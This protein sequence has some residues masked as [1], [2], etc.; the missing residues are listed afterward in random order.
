MDWGWRGKLLFHLVP[1]K[2]SIN[3]IVF[4]QCFG[5]LELAMESQQCVDMTYKTQLTGGWPPPQPDAMW[6][7][8]WLLPY[9][10][11][12]RKT[13]VLTELIDCE[14]VWGGEGVG[15]VFISW[16]DIPPPLETD[17]SL[18]SYSAGLASINIDS[19]VWN[20]HKH[21]VWELF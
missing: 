13:G 16:R 5:Y 19:S 18:S 20:L 17:P 10:R 11:M 2:Q 4:Q 15:N 6:W 7:G 8:L 3:F 12:S 21:E 1:C 14:K 9:D